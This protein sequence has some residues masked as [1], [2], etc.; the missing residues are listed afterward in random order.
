MSELEKEQAQQI[1]E[2]LMERSRE[3]SVTSKKLSIGKDG[4]ALWQ[5]HQH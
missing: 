3:I 1:K 5:D 4:Y 2:E